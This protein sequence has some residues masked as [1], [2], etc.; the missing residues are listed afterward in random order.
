MA[1]R[2]EGWKVYPYYVDLEDK[3][4][5]CSMQVWWSK[6]TFRVCPGNRLLKFSVLQNISL[7]LHRHMLIGINLV[8]TV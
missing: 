2:K 8:V 4:S 7:S 6:P 5:D 3:R 1:F